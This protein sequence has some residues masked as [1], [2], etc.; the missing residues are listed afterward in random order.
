MPLPYGLYTLP[1][2]SWVSRLGRSPAW[3]LTNGTPAALIA[4]LA[5][6]GIVVMAAAV[7]RLLL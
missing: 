6:V 3:Y 7:L 4:R 1:S 5:Q 2:S